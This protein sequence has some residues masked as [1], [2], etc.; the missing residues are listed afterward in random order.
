M[1]RHGDLLILPAILPDGAYRIRRNRRGHLVLA[2][3]EATGHAHIVADKDAS[4][5][6]LITPDDSEELRQRFLLV[7][8]EQGATITHQEHAPLVIP[9]GVWEVRRQREYTPAAPVIV[10]D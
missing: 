5:Y 8:A 9:P 1:Y 6:D 3:G 10:G 4:L 7:E 2:L